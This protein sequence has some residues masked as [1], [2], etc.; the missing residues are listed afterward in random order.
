M[1]DSLEAFFDLVTV[2]IYQ[3]GTL[4][5]LVESPAE[6]R[7]ALKPPRAGASLTWRDQDEA[8]ALIRTAATQGNY[9]ALITDGAKAPGQE[10][11]PCATKQ[12]RFFRPEISDTEAGVLLT[13]ASR[14]HASV[15][16]ARLQMRGMLARELEPFG[17]Y[18]GYQ[19]LYL[20]APFL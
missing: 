11:R 8:T 1:T 17:P 18:R 14:L 13:Q 16:L 6:H 3:Q 7:L 20:P 19:Q 5:V 10:M 12:I 4:F 2:R 15:L 9:L